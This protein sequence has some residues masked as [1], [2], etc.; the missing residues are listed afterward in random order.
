M[1]YNDTKAI[2][3]NCT[4]D[5][6][7][8]AWFPEIPNGRPTQAKLKALVADIEYALDGCSSC[9]KKD[10]CLAEGMQEENLPHGIWGGLL[11]GE[12]IKLLGHVRSDFA[13]QSDKGR[14][15]DF[16]DRLALMM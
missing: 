13:M 10:E 3:G 14:A 1:N 4:G 12:R 16:S 5:A 6:N 8:D 15:L 7:P 11:A 9:L 2:I